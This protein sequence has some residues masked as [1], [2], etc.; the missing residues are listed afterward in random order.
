MI[1]TR[2]DVDLGPVL[3]SL[4][5]EDVVVWDNSKREVDV[6]T[7]G[8]RLAIAKAKNSI[9]Y[10]QDDDIVHSKKNQRKILSEYE[11]GV[12]TGCMWDAWSQGARDQGIARGYDDLV[13]A[14]SG[15]VYD[16]NVPGDAVS[17][18]LEWWPA[19]DFFFLWA[20][21][22]IGVLAPT[23]QIDV[24][25]TALPC[26]ENDNRMCNLPNA[27]LQKKEAISRARKI[28]DRSKVAA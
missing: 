11:P 5:F 13:F 3:K 10:S 1:V 16:A 22:I 8:R 28:R 21:T 15:S 19:D 23:K 9:I 20:D 24:R 14:G 6:M 27:V 26:A 17:R 7:Y 25:F 12:L 18:Y 2:G 4:I